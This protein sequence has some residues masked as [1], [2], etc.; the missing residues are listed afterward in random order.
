MAGIPGYDAA[1]GKG[2]TGD[3]AS[4]LHD[5]FGTGDGQI[6]GVNVRDAALYLMNGPTEFKEEGGRIVAETDKKELLNYAHEGG[7]YHSTTS[8]FEKKPGDEFSSTIN[9]KRSIITSTRAAKSTRVGRPFVVERKAH[10]DKPSGGIEDPKKTQPVG[11]EGTGGGDPL[12][13]PV[14]DEGTGGGDPLKSPVGD[15]GG[16]GGGNPLF[17]PV[18]DADGG[19]PVNPNMAGHATYLEVYSAGMAAAQEASAASIASAE[20]DAA[21]QFQMASVDDPLVASSFSDFGASPLQMSS[22][23]F[24]GTADLQTDIYLH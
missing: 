21:E 10:T 8:G 5:L 16:S 23:E 9:G 12:K 15:G 6:N 1:H 3:F 20:H 14:G 19:G 18:G 2:N 17:Q 22:F 4:T 13:Q 11:D 7:Y 24:V